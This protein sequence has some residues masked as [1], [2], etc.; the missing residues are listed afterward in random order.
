MLFDFLE[1]ITEGGERRGCGRETL[2]V[3][4]ATITAADRLRMGGRKALRVARADMNESNGKVNER[5]LNLDW[6]RRKAK[7]G[8]LFC[9]ISD[10]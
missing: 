7:D 4:L 3:V 6:A 10:Q 8:G 2:F 5:Q 9:L 1:T